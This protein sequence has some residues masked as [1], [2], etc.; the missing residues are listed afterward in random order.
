MARNNISVTKDYR[1][2]RS[3][4][5]NRD[6]CPQKHRRLKNSM[7]KY[8]FL[9]SFPVVC[10]Q[11]GGTQ[12]I[13]K[14]GQHRLAIAE[15]LGYAIPY[16]VES[17]DFDIA[18]VNSAAV[19][20][21]FRDYLEKWA[22]HGKQDYQEAIDFADAHK[23]PVGLACGILVGDQGAKHVA[24]DVIAGTFR[25]KDRESAE[26]VASLY[27]GLVAMSPAL[28]NRS[29]IAACQAVLLLPNFSSERLIHGASKCRDRL[30]S[31]STRDAYLDLF[32]SIYNFNRQKLV[33]IKM[34]VLQIMRD[35]N[36]C[37]PGKSKKKPRD[38]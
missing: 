37:T 22:K 7:A 25:I 30:V 4:I 24:K 36:P 6:L 13:V 2:F 34:P 20:W 33:P 28:K 11:N 29:C 32:E 17:T 16:I 15:E 26:G 31:Y 21:R 12:L 14:D 23:I 35:R 38:S 19:S 8:G 1:K 10:H 18:E 3:N 9:R 5:D 27:C